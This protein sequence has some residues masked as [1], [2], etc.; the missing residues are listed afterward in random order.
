VGAL[1][2]PLVLAAPRQDRPNQ[3][4][5]RCVELPGL[6]NERLVPEFSNQTS[7]FVGAVSASKYATLVSGGT[8]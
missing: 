8:K 1:F 5:H 3:L 4:H 6:V 7:F 2:K